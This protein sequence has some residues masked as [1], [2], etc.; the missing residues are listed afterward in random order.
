MNKN[1][2]TPVQI[3][4]RIVIIIIVIVILLL[5]SFAMV[6]F[7]P[8]V[9][10]SLASF[11]TLFTA[12]EQLIVSLDKVSVREGSDT[13]LSFKQT[14]GKSEGYYELSYSCSKISSNTS[15]DIMSDEGSTNLSCDTPLMLPITPSSTTSYS[16]NITPIG[17]EVSYDQPILITIKHINESSTVATGTATLT[18][19][20]ETSEEEAS[21]V[22]ATST[23]VTTSKPPTVVSPTTNYHPS[24]ARLTAQM[25]SVNV[26]TNGKA[27][28]TFYVTNTGGQ[29]SNSWTFSANLPRSIGQTVYNS[30]YQSSIPAGGTSTMYLTFY[31]AEAGTINVY[32]Q[33]SSFSATLR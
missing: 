14:G 29:R 12:K 23:P 25:G 30:P 32:V 21:P 28:V 15:L 33:N 20:G 9:F 7:V 17:K 27:V 22:V 13:T 11:R 31:N 1:E 8:K 6:R 2:V 4:I 5:V 18:V 24:P 19:L 10:S 16:T 3:A 26:D